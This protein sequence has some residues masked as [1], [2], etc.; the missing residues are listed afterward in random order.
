MERFSVTALFVLALI[1]ASFTII[2]QDKQSDQTTI[3][4]NQ[5]SIEWLSFEEAVEKSDQD[6]RKILIEIYT[7]WCTWCK[8]MDTITLDQPPLLPTSTT[9]ITR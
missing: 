2:D 3:Q 7:D 5:T 6:G 9:I 1:A 8:R 4:E